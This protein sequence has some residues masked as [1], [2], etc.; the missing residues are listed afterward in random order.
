MMTESE[1]RESLAKT[2]QAR[3]AERDEMHRQQRIWVGETSD[4]NI[5]VRARH[6]CEEAQARVIWYNAQIAIF[7]WL[8]SSPSESHTEQHT[9]SQGEKQ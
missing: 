1:V 8:L 3:E 5:A 6:M 2:Q 9:E 4:I 7:D